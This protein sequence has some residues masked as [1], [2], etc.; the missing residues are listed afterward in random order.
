[1]YRI[2]MQLLLCNIKYEEYLQ[3]SIDFNQTKTIDGHWLFVQTMYS[4]IVT[5]LSR[6]LL[7]GVNKGTP[8]TTQED[9]RVEKKSI[10]RMYW[11]A[12]QKA[13]VILW[14]YCR[15]YTLGSFS[16]L[17]FL[18]YFLSCVILLL[19]LIIVILLRLINN[20]IF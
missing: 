18:L 6:I 9:G 8:F 17:L 7:C 14:C 11:W 12:L 16:Y 15:T 20:Y 1:M 10:W 5:I 3:S 2:T 19:I 13:L 4:I